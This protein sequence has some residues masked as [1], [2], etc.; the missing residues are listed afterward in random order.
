MTYHGE[1]FD[2]R[3][4]HFRANDAEWRIQA[5][6]GMRRAFHTPTYCAAIALTAIFGSDIVDVSGNARRSDS[7]LFSLAELHQFA[8]RARMSAEVP[9]NSVSFTDYLDDPACRGTYVLIPDPRD[10]S[11]PHSL[12][13]IPSFQQ[14]AYHHVWYPTYRV[15][16]ANIPIRDDY[17]VPA[18][19]LG[20]IYA[21]ALIASEWT[22]WMEPIGSR[23]AVC[24]FEDTP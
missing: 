3:Y 5:A 21:S 15:I 10:S 14:T 1:I 6:L 23:F 19:E 8:I 16:D 4:Y 12:A 22:E 7:L 13:V 17:T 2:D 9:P 11:R 24:F 18:D 20:I